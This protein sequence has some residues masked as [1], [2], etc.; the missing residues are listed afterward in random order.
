MFWK[1]SGKLATIVL[2]AALPSLAHSQTTD[3]AVPVA[4]DNV[5]VTSDTD[6]VDSEANDP[7]PCEDVGQPGAYFEQSADCGCQDCGC[8]QSTCGCE[9][10]RGIGLL[11]IARALR[12]FGDTSGY[13]SYRSIFGGWSE[14]EGDLDTLNSQ[15]VFNDGFV[16]GTAKGIYLNSNTRVERE[17]SWRNNSAENLGGIGLPLFLDGRMNNFSTMV[18]VIREFR[19]NC[20]LKPYVGLGAGASRQDGEFN[21]NAVDLELDDWAFAYQGIAGLKFEKSSR[22]SLF[23]EYRYFGN[24][25]TDLEASTAG[26]TSFDISDFEYTAENVVFGLQFKR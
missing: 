6:Y 15:F 10:G 4:A 22:V 26:G 3:E 5:I 20:R 2:L 24:S 18:N 25:E 9:C 8:Q 11:R 21:V 12:P 23:A 19:P 14:T 13:D 7:C 16:L 17:A 1:N